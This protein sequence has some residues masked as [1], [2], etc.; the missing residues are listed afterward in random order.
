MSSKKNEDGLI[1]LLDEFFINK[2][3]EDL[4]TNAINQYNELESMMLKCHQILKDIYKIQSNIN[5]V[6]KE[7]QMNNQPSIKKYLYIPNNEYKKNT[8][9]IRNKIFKNKINITSYKR[10][11]RNDSKNKNIRRNSFGHFESSIH[12]KSLKRININLIPKNNENKIGNIFYNKRTKIGKLKKDKQ[13]GVDYVIICGKLYENISKIFELDYEI[14]LQKIIKVSPDKEEEKEEKKEE[15]KKEEKK[16]ETPETKETTETPMPPETTETKV[17]KLEINTEKN[18]LGK[19]G[20]EKKGIKEY[21]VDFYPIKTIQLN[22]G[23][24]VSFIENEKKIIEKKKE[25]EEWEKKTE[26][27]SKKEDIIKFLEKHNLSLEKLTKEELEKINDLSKEEKD[28]I[29]DF[30]SNDKI[31]RANKIQDILFNE[32]K[33]SLQLSIKT[34]NLLNPNNNDSTNKAMDPKTIIKKKK[35][36]AK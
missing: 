26:E 15:D 14:E 13:Y 29:S 36:N 6:E 11:T 23:N 18:Y 4:E 7:N 32:G 8:Y 3:L 12:K 5:I 35:K 31:K 24:A 20:D 17:E 30:L 27:E 2:G 33:P 9:K 25:E 22:I 10:K 16:G 19:K 34:Q 1:F 21:I 28:I